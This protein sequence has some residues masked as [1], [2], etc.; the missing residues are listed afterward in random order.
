MEP[1][2]R[3]DANL[4]AYPVDKSPQ[5]PQSTESISKAIAKCIL[6]FLKYNAIRQHWKELVE[7]ISHATQNMAHMEKLVERSIWHETQNMA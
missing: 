3:R 7:N 1:N 4:L 5:T 6:V 2:N